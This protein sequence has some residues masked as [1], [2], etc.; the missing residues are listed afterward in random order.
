MAQLAQQAKLIEL[1][2]EALTTL[3]A[4]AAGGGELLRRVDLFS[5]KETTGSVARLQQRVLKALEECDAITAVQPNG[6]RTF[7]L[8]GVNKPE[9][10]RELLADDA[11]ISGVLWPQAQLPVAQLP[12]AAEPPEPLGSGAEPAGGAEPASGEPS[13]LAEVMLTM[14]KAVQTV[15]EAVG[16]LH[17]RIDQLHERLDQLETKLDKPVEPDVE[18]KALIDQSTSLTKQL[19]ARLIE[20]ENNALPRLGEA[21]A[22]QLKP[23]DELLY[24]HG[25]QPEPVKVMNVRRDKGSPIT[26]TVMRPDGKY[27]PVTPKYLSRKKVA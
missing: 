10:C 26:V 12:V 27:A 8:W 2:H 15:G 19:T 4:A 13:G 16:R 11:K 20:A 22:V 6:P 23:G 9:L 17:G 25:A 21:D 5:E 1:V 14:L 3:L 7:Q 18:L 24:F